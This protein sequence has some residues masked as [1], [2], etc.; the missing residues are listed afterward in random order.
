MTGPENTFVSAAPSRDADAD[1]RYTFTGWKVG[2]TVYAAGDALPPMTKNVTYTHST[3]F[4][5]AGHHTPDAVK[6]DDTS[7]RSA[8]VRPLNARR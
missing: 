7:Q 2:A 1:Y 3:I 5:P 8:P 4:S 6:P